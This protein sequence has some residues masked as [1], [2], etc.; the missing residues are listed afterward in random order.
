MCA[1]PSL[2]CSSPA[3]L[4]VLVSLTRFQVSM[5]LRVS[6][7]RFCNNDASLPIDRVRLSSVPRCL[8]YYEGT[9]T[10]CAE[11]DFTYGFVSP[12]Q[13]LLPVRFLAAETSARTRP[14]YSLAPSAWLTG[15]TQDLPGSWRILPAPM[16]CSQTPASLD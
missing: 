9:K 5:S 14:V 1:M 4:F 6:L 2:D 11:Y 8:Q 15:Q 12:L 16:P 3:W 7:K 13:S 10:S